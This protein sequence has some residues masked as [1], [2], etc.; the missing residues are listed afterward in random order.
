[1]GGVPTGALTGCGDGTGTGCTG[2]KVAASGLLDPLLEPALEG[3]GGALDLGAS[4]LTD[5][6]GADILGCCTVTDGADAEGARFSG[7]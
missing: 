4:T 1:M 6:A 7:V 2:E 5:G 3:A